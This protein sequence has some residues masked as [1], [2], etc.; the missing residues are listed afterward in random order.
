MTFNEAREIIYQHFA[1]NWSPPSP[2]VPYK[3]DGESY[4]PTGVLEWVRLVVRQTGGGQHTLGKTGNRIFRRRG[5]V[6]VQLQA[7]VDRGLLRLDELGQEALGILEGKTISQVSLLNGNYQEK[8][9]DGTW[10]TGSVTVSFTYDE[11]K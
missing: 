1:D 11:L 6:L 10:E 4:D 3:F 9:P 5:I 7:P 2:A 8:G